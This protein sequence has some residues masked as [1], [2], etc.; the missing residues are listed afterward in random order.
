MKLNLGNYGGLLFDYN[1]VMNSI[2]NSSFSLETNDNLNDV[3]KVNPIEYKYYPDE[4]KGSNRMLREII[5]DADKITICRAGCW[6]R[7]YNVDVMPHFTLA[8]L[9]TKESR[10]RLLHF[11]LLHLLSNKY[12]PKK[13]KI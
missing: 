11:K 6:K 12:T 13:M 10:L 4:F 1:A 2:R 5:L 7:K 3:T 8:K 9:A